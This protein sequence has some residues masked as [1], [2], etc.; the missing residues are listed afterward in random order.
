MYNFICQWKVKMEEEASF[1]FRQKVSVRQPMDGTGSGEIDRNCAP[2][3]YTKRLQPG[4][5][6]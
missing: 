2:R 4:A 3:R 6:I 5:S 1:Y